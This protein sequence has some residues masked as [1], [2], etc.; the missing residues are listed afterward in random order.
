MP[1]FGTL[2]AHIWPKSARVEA[3]GDLLNWFGFIVLEWSHPPGSNRRPADYESADPMGPISLTAYVIETFVCASVFC[4]NPC[5][6][7]PRPEAKSSLARPIPGWYASTRGAIWRP[8]SGATLIRP[9]REN[10]PRQRP[11]LRACFHKSLRGP[12]ANSILDEYLD[13]WLHAGS[14]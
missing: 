9:F 1:E 3:L 8:A 6:I 7:A 5:E 11:N 10:A 4:Q 13:W 12:E 14:R 2:L